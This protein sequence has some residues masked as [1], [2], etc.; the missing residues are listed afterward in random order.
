MQHTDET[1]IL[2]ADPA[3]SLSLIGSNIVYLMG[4]SF[5]VGSLFTILILILLDVMRRRAIA[6]NNG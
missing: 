4:F 6:K 5:I 3:A 1:I 2:S